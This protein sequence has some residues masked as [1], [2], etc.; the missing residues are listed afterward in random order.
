MKSQNIFEETHKLF[1]VIL[2]IDERLQCV[3]ER[4]CAMRWSILSQFEFLRW[5]ERA[6][7]SC[8][9][10]ANNT[11]DYKYITWWHFIY[12]KKNLIS[13][14]GTNDDERKKPEAHLT[15]F[16]VVFVKKFR[17]YN[18]THVVF[19]FYLFVDDYKLHV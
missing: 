3:S 15:S 17:F 2:A 11:T 6:A 18:E 8:L 1:F 4:R 12:P 16:F 19:R 9:H 14:T 10:N 7:A 13:C 5:C